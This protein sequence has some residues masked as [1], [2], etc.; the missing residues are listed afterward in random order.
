MKVRFLK[1]MDSIVD[2]SGTLQTEIVQGIELEI[3]PVVAKNLIAR[4]MVEEIKPQQA[5]KIEVEQQA[6]G[7]I[8]MGNVAYA[9]KVGN[10]GLIKNLSEVVQPKMTMAGV[11][12]TKE[13]IEGQVIVLQKVEFRK[14]TA[15]GA[16]EGAEYASVQILQT[17]GLSAWLNVGAEQVV[18]TLKQVATQ[19]P[20]SA[21]F[22][23]RKNPKSK[24]TYWVLE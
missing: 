9:V 23:S 19:L 2:E 22:L 17:N 4:G 6:P 18:E 12:V 11:Q 8:G 3:H 20:L 14:S 1:P 21:K 15:Q 24:R 5:I 10:G 16:K 13:E 7:V